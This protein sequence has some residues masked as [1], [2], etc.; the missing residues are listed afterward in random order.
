MGILPLDHRRQRWHGEGYTEPLIVG[1]VIQVDSIYLGCS[2]Q[3]D[4]AYVKALAAAV[5]T[6]ADAD[7]LA[8]SC[9]VNREGMAQLEAGFAALGL[10]WIASKGNFIAVDFARDT[11]AINQAL[12]REGVIVR[13]MAGYRMPNFLRVSIGLPK[14]N[15][16]FLEALAKV[17]SA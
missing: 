10:S 17:L 11:A 1:D 16:R 14:E 12:L 8:A 3:C 5:A 4:P 9:K 7:Y 6:L 13:P 15:A 2:L